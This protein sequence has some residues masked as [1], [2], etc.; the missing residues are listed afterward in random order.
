MDEPG[1]DLE[2]TQDTSEGISRRALLNSAGVLGGAAVAAALLPVGA[3]AMDLAQTTG[4]TATR[5]SLTIDSYE[6]AAFQELSGITSEVTPV[7]YLESTDTSLTLSKLPGK[8]KPPSLVLKRGL[9]GAMELSAWHEAVRKGDIAAARKNATLTIFNAEGIAVGKY[10]LQNA[11][12]SKLEV[13]GLKAGAST[14][15][16]ETVTLV[17]ENLQ[18]L[19]P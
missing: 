6:I 11:W 19:K 8:S 13:A 18:R 5:F 7:E 4:I 9:T 1:P 14:V 2:T 10:W 15:L 16:M 12:P 17:C 3:A